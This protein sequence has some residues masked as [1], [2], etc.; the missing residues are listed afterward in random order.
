[1]PLKK[2]LVGGNAL[3]P[4]NPLAGFELD[5][6]VDQQEGIAVGQDTLDSVDIEHHPLAT[7]IL[8]F[9]GDLLVLVILAQPLGKFDIALMTRAGGEDLA[10]DRGTGQV[11]VAQQIKQLVPGRL[12]AEAQL[13]VVEDAIIPDKHLAV[14]LQRLFDLILVD[15][16]QRL[17]ADHHRIIQAAAFDQSLGQQHLH[18]MEK[19]EGARR[20]EIADKFFLQREQ[21]GMLAAQRRVLVIDHHRDAEIVQRQGHDVGAA[22][23]VIIGQGIGNHDV[24]LESFLLNDPRFQQRLH[25]GHG[26]AVTDRRFPGGQ[27]DQ[28]IVDLQPGHRRQHMLHGIDGAS[29]LVQI[30]AAQAVDRIILHHIIHQCRHFHIGFQVRPAEYNAVIFRRRFESD[31]R[32]LPGMQSGA[33]K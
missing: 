4:D 6:A 21:A 1:M 20:G 22:L 11:E 17:V 5:D 33:G 12:I 19:A 8:V 15:L 10:F 7:D 13:A 14:N 31:G 18:L 26:A 24:I 28:E 3:H 23:V 16:L 9:A 32:P 25:I 27:L 2:M 29:F 30:G